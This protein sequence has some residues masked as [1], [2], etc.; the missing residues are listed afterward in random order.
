MAVAFRS[1]PREKEGA[2]ECELRHG[3]HTAKAPHTG[4]QPP[5][6]NECTRGA[7]GWVGAGTD[8][9]EY[10]EVRLTRV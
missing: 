6:T 1:T 8:V 7:G 9:C 2:G 10:F 3:S 5:A 4:H